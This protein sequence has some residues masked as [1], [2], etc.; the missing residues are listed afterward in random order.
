MMNNNDIPRFIKWAGGKL[1]LLDQL[2]PLFPKKFNNYFEPFV[3]SGAVAFYILSTFQPNNVFLSDTNGELINAFTVIKTAP[4]PLITKLKRHKKNHIVNGS[5]YYYK[6]RQINPLGLSSIDRAARFIYLN[7]TC[8]NGLYRVNS[9]GQFNVPIGSYTNPDIVQEDKIKRINKILR[10]PGIQLATQHFKDAIQHAKAGDFIY[11][12]P[13]Y[14]PI[15]KG[16]S[17][18]TYTKDAFLENEQKILAQIFIEL[19][20]R[21]CFVMESNSN[22]SFIK[23]LYSDYNFNFVKAKRLINSNAA[24]R[25]KITELIITNY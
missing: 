12:D 20:K 11:F 23:K 19:D 4:N 6:L 9:H 24:G 14:H 10:I 7:K 16:K 21:G 25:G 1:Q 2:K 13:P 22:T 3:G 17:F 15:A 5:A 18:T 8:F